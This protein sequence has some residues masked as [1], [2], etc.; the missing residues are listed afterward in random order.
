MFPRHPSLP[1]LKLSFLVSINISHQISQL[2]LNFNAKNNT[3]KKKISIYSIHSPLTDF[4]PNTQVCWKKITDQKL[5]TVRKN[6]TL[7]NSSS[8]KCLMFRHTVLFILSKEV[9]T[10]CSIQ[11]QIFQLIKGSM[12]Y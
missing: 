4:K 7:L 9:P 2:N 11:I 3:N 5:I 1:L 12:E 10:G 6:Q 8:K